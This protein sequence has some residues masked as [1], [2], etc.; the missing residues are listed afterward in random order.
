MQ[1]DILY[2]QSDIFCI[3]WT[4]YISLKNKLT[5]LLVKTLNVTFIVTHECISLIIQLGKEQL[6]NRHCGALIQT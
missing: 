2:I 3:Q 5:R 4:S 1:V 6:I